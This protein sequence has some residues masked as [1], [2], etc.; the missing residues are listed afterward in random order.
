MQNISAISDLKFRTSYGV[1]G[2]QAIPPYLSLALV[3]PFGEGVF[4]SPN[5]SE[6]FTGQ[7]PLSYVN[8]DLKWETTRQL[9]IGID[10]ALLNN[11][12]TV[13]ADYYKRKPSTYY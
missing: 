9:D 7:E 6:V 13:T 10:L 4:N 12:I 5:G 8:P 3:G 2:N 11:R 1:I